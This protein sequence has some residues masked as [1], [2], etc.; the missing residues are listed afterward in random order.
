MSKKCVNCGAELSGS[1]AF[2]P[3]CETSQY[4]KKTVR[5]PRLWRKKARIAAIFLTILALAAALGYCAAR[6]GTWEGSGTVRYSDKDGTYELL[7]AFFPDDI[8]NGRP[9][10]GKT[11]SLSEGETSA[12]T[13]MIGVYQDGELL[14]AEVFFEKVER[15]AIEVNSDDGGGLTLTEPTYDANFV[16]AVSVSQITYTGTSGANELIWILTMKNGDI[17]RLRQTFEVLPLIHQVYTWEDTALDTMEDLEA[18]LL[19]VGEEVP[20]DTI[21]DIYLPP[22]TYTGELRI[23][24]RAVNLYGCTDGAARTTFTETVFINADKPSYVLLSD[25]NFAGSG[26]MGLSAAASV[27]MVNCAFSGW[28]VG[29]VAQDGGMIAVERCLFQNNGVGFKYNT[30]AWHSFSDIFPDCTITGNDIGVQFARMKGTITI[31]FAG[32]VFS[33]NGIDIDNQAQY[34]IDT[35]GAIFE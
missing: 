10:A 34:P 17:I 18:L 19:R 12:D 13:V 9:I 6:P 28:D 33:G 16:P 1:A 7:A 8:R 32:S 26:G 23:L 11:V 3:Y 5:L 14:D 35:T 25:L 22:V 4:E 27:Y 20:E 31:D 29:A 2:C 15:C 30:M 21:V 24:S